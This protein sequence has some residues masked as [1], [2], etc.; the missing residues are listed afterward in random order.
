MVLLLA[1]LASVGLD[2]DLREGLTRVLGSTTIQDA[3][4]VYR[5]IRLAKPGGLGQVNQHDVAGEPTITLLEAMSLA[6]DRDLVARQ[7][8]L[9]FAD[10]FDS[11]LPS[12]RRSIDQKRKVETVIIAA[13]LEFLANHPDTLIARKR[14]LETAREASSRAARVLDLGWPDD[15]LGVTELDD[16]DHWLRDDGHA[17]NPG[18]TADLVT[19]GLFVALRDGTIP[20]PIEWAWSC[21]AG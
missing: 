17:R 16:F 15:P 19:A 4:L 8:D 20:L 14:G 13:S 21:P 12:I 10:V 6:A 9:K 11:V 5:A 7:Y 3:G 1:P 2:E 18:A